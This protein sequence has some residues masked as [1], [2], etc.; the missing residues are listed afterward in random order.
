LELLFDE[1]LHPFYIFQIA[2]IILWSLD[3]YYYYA[4]CIFVIS[5]GSAIS[6][7]LE[8]KKT[9]KKINEMAKFE[10]QVNVWR[11][12]TWWTLSSTELVPGDIFEITPGILFNLTDERCSSDHAL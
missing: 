2:S 10:C 6:T 9:M 3:D 4:S 5:A 12:S 7:L 1:V 11:G 8:T